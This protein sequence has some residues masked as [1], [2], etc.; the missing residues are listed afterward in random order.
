MEKTK[1][2]DAQSKV[3]TINISGMTCASCAGAIERGL[4][5]MPGVKEAGVNL[6]AEKANVEFDPGQVGLE[7]IVKKIDSLGYKAVLPEAGEEPGGAE[8][9][10]TEELRALKLRLIASIVLGGLVMGL[11]MHGIV[12]LPVHGS[13]MN[14]I[15]LS[16]ATPVQ[17]WAGWRFYRGAY[18][19][20]SHGSANMDVLIATGTSAAYF[21]SVAVTFFP[22]LFSGYGEGVYYD[23]STMIIALILLGKYLE[24]KSRGRASEAIKRLVKL[25]PKTA[26]VVRD[27]TEV[28]I[29]VEEVA[30]GDVLVVRPGE[31]IPVDGVVVGGFSSVDESMLT[32][33]SI[34]VEKKEGGQVIG[35][36]INLTGSFRFRAS[37]VGKDTM[38]AGIIKLVEEAQG[39]KAPI[40]RLADR[41]AGVFVP[42]VIVIA[43]ITFIAWYASGA[44]FTFSM[45]NF[46]AVLIIAC[47]CAMGLATPTAIMVGT[48]R[49]AEKG[50][51]IRGGEILERAAR[52]NTVVLD[53]TGTITEG[54]PRVTDVI[55]LSGLDSRALLEYAAAVESLSEHPL[56]KAIVQKAK[57][58]SVRIHEAEGFDAMPGFGARAMLSDKKILLGNEALLKNNGIDTGVA[59]EKAAELAAQGKTAIYVVVSGGVAGIIAAADTAKPGSKEAVMGLRGMGLDVIMLTGDNE[60]VARAVAS[61]VGIENVIANVLPDGKEKEVARLQAEGRVVAMVG[62]GIN[63]APALARADVGVAIGTGTDVAIEA[64]DMTLV[65]SDLGDVVTAFKISRRT[66]RVIKQNLFWAFFYNVVGI[67]VAGG[68]L[69]PA[70]GILLKPI[71]AAAAMAFSSVSVV[72]NSLRL[73][74]L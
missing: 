51:I 1:E 66:L 55:A 23:T 37:K 70:F 74:K 64:S 30:V 73:R 17:F 29:T 42:V 3:C 63:D 69:F 15:L 56:A 34:P 71:F 38:L 43:A 52:I 58:E 19:N 72:S 25:R 33:E 67:P 49:G 50:V 6:A 36:T 31:K 53:K 13:L 68:A 9:E 40:Q 26:R 39:S 48:G 8:A 18:A 59:S 62:D 12:K 21:Y 16:L 11:S 65:K 5:K 22:G 32:G 54:R 24:A 7:D 35:A 10:K 61:E 46:I 44:G 41:V 57:E 45:L 27:G 14:Y 60:A 20:L 4:R 47:P 28:E 2:K